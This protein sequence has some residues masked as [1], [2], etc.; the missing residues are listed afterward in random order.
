[1]T[2]SGNSLLRDEAYVDGRW[3]VAASGATFEVTDP[4]TDEVLTRVADLGA[5]ET[6]AAI[7]AADR[8]F[9]DWRQRTAKDRAALLQKWFHLIVKHTD[10]LATL[11]TAEQGKPLAESKGEVA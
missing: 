2:L 7:A 10:E 6:E 3:V 5:G 11:M 1:M 4:A 8:A 9:A